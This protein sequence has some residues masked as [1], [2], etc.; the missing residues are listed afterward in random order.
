MLETYPVVVVRGTVDTLLIYTVPFLVFDKESEPMIEIF[1]ALV[2]RG[3]V[4]TLLVYI[5]PFDVRARF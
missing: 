4:Y 1:L 2:V 5:V 3:T